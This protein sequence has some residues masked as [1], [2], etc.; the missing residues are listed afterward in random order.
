VEPKQQKR[1]VQLMQDQ[2]LSPAFPF[3]PFLISRFL[4]FSLTTQA[5]VPKL[6]LEKRPGNIIQA[7]QAPKSTAKRAKHLQLMRIR[8]IKKFSHMQLCSW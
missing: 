4:N 6:R 2:S 8:S 5:Q 1:P 3:S 7:L